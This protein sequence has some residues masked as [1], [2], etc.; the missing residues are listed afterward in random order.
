MS[1]DLLCPLCQKVI[2]EKIYD[3]GIGSPL[4]YIAMCRTKYDHRKAS[5]VFW[6][7]R[8]KAGTLCRKCAKEHFP[9]GTSYAIRHYGYRGEKEFAYGGVGGS[10]RFASKQEAEDSAARLTEKFKH[11]YWVEELPI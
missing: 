2:G 1:K 5:R 9:D 7:E 3:G 11:K 10:C 6:K 8:G 4:G